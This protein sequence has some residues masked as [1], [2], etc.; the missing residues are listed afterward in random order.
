LQHEALTFSSDG[1][2]TPWIRT[3]LMAN[4]NGG[5]S[6]NEP[7]DQ[8]NSAHGLTMAVTLNPSPTDNNKLPSIDNSLIVE[9]PTAKQTPFLQMLMPSPQPFQPFPWDSQCYFRETLVLETNQ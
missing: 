1:C 7:T 2:G 9:I 6:R 3:S 4:Y 5:F 8:V